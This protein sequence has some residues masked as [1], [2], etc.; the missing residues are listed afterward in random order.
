MARQ[1]VARDSEALKEVLANLEKGAQEDFG[2][3]F[4]YPEFKDALEVV[5]QAR[6]SAFIYRRIG[7]LPDIDFLNLIEALKNAETKA[8]GVSKPKN[9]R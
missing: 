9:K 4:S 1:V 6:Y 3:S 7:H 2:I 8:P 5:R